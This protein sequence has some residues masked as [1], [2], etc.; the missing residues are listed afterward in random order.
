MGAGKS[1]IGKAL[2]QQRSMPYIDLDSYIERRVALSISR[3]FEVYGEDYFR[4]E[5]FYA[6]TDLFQLD[7]AII[8]LGGGS[9]THHNLA[10]KIRN[11]GLL[12][13]LE[14]KPDFLYSRLKE[15]K[16]TRPLLAELNESELLK[17]IEEQLEKRTA[18]Y[19]K[20]QFKLNVE[21]KSIEEITATLNNYLDLF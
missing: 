12:I 10:A 8:G 19:Q 4:N 5:E 20:A 18:T 1:T 14:A 9:L 15:E 16:N 21:N 17:F 3:I 6:I 11:N 2:A 7:N 13:Y